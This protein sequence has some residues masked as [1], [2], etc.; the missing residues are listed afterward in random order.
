[1]AIVVGWRLSFGGIQVKIAVHTLALTLAL[2]IANTALA[3]VP[4]KDVMK[5]AA[6]ANPVERLSCFDA[7]A[8]SKGLTTKTVETPAAG[9]GKWS[10][11]TTTDPLTDKSIYIAMLDASSGRG[12]LGE[13]IG[14]VVRCAKNKTEL[15]INWNS[16][17]GTDT[18][19]VTH[20]V[21]KLKAE[22]HTWDVS[23][24]HT[25]S[26][27][28]GSPVATLKEM[29]KNTSFVANVTPYSESPVTATFDV[30]G[31]EAA[32]SDIRKGCSW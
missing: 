22:T 32:F 2:V 25:S 15:Y 5:C 10:T 9:K 21:G 16:F 27:Y 17:L 6:L 14:L 28:P 18:A 7:L 24:D 23:T 19:R 13:Q 1:M 8:E 29:T 4:E 30:S 20:R 12:R 3:D 31:A 11:S 26:F